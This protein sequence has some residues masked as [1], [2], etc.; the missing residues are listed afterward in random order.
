MRE[1]GRS[2]G[3]ISGLAS[4]PLVVLWPFPFDS[5]PCNF[6]FGCARFYEGVQSRFQCDRVLLRVRRHAHLAT[7]HRGHALYA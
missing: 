7:R 5:G 2:C 3:L 4:L 6:A 1:R